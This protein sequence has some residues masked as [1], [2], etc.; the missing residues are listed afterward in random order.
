MRAI[1]I[2][3]GQPW[4]I[5]PEMLQT[6]FDI[7]DRRADIAAV[8]RQLGRKLENT[9]VT[10]VQATATG[11]VAVIPVQGVIFRHANM[12]TQVSGATSI[13]ELATDFN[14]A[15]NDPTIERIVLNIDSPGGA[16]AG[17]QEFANQIYNARGIKPITAYVGD[18]GA[19]A[20]YWI[21]SAADRI[22]AAKSARIGSIGVIA[23]ISDES[24]KDAKEG[25]KTY[26]F[27]NSASPMKRPDLESDEGKSEVQSIVDTLGEYFIG[28]VAR[29]RGVTAQTVESDF[30]RGGVLMAIDAQAVGMIDAVGTFDDSLVVS[31]STQTSPLK[32]AAKDKTER[33]TNGTF[34]KSLWCS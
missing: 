8:E 15:L 24:E 16:V 23:Q 21:A 2:A 5:I 7:A 6:V 12:L 25:I 22:I 4:A 26:Q 19:S 20:A 27:I 18:T 14:T 17:I 28:D 31:E 9:Q 1:D 33:R 34:S 3:Q 11:N 30:G 32:M 13:G 29:N 10:S